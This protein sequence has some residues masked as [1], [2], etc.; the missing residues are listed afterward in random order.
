[1]KNWFGLLGA[2]GLLAVFV[3]VPAHV[4]GQKPVVQAQEQ[5]DHEHQGERDAKGAGAAEQRPGMMNPEMMKKMM[6]D[7]K[8][9]DAKLEALVQRMNAA[10]GPEKTEAIAALLTALVQERPAMR[11]SMMGMM[12]MK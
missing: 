9:G 6:S 1:M 5:H 11:A 4:H 2:A 12:N 8:A 3:G 7:M 10:T